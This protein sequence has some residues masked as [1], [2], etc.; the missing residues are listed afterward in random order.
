MTRFRLPLFMLAAAS[1]CALLAV[2]SRADDEPK[3]P[4]KPITGDAEAAV[5]ATVDREI[6]KVWERDGVTP[7]VSK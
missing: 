3:A 2:S 6:S 4:E 7:T 5:T 1:L